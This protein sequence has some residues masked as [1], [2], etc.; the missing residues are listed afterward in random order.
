MSEASAEAAKVGIDVERLAAAVQVYRAAKAA[1]DLAAGALKVAT[2]ENVRA[3]NA[4]ER[5]EHGLNEEFD[6]MVV[7]GEE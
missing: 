5:A 1:A 2:Q 3:K 7:G 6:R 4:L